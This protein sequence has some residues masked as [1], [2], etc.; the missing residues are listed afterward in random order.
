[1]TIDNELRAVDH[2]ASHA[3]PAVVMRYREAGILTWALLHQIEAEVLA[4]LRATGDHDV[5]VLNMMR[6][7]EALGYPSDDRPASFEGKQLVPIIMGKIEKEWWRV[8]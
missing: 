2:A 1:M 5:D 8:H 3:V 6:S 4:E 7:A